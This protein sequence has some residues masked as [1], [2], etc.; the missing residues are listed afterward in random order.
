VNLA[1]LSMSRAAGRRASRPSAPRW[2]PA[3]GSWRG[4]RWRK[5]GV[6]AAVGR[7]LGIA[8]AFV[9]LQQLLAAAPFDLPRLR[10]V[11]VDGRV[12]FFALA[13]SAITA[14]LFGILPAMRSAS[15]GA[16]YETLKSTA[17]SNAGGPTGLRLR[18]MLVALEVGLC[19]ALLVTAGL[20]L[21]SFMRL[22]TIPR[23]FDIERVMAVDVALPWTKYSK[24]TDVTRF[25]EHVLEQAR[26]MR[27]C[28]RRPVSSY[29][30]LE[31]ESWI[32]IVGTENDTRPESQLP[33]P[34]LRFISRAISRRCTSP[35]RGP[36]FHG[37]R[38]Q[39]SDRRHFA[40]PGAQT[41]AESGPR[42]AQTDGYG[43][44]S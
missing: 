15:S 38:P 2:E 26:A 32:D 24:D 13:L 27:E 20:F 36:R 9:G 18:N 11:S 23:G 7:R 29:L 19:A 34:N 37:C 22:T 6:L 8:L 33:N 40:K 43:Q 31:G 12:L 35:A 41:L 39:P 14:L 10:D 1:N 42:R 44:A 3:A 4:N 30:P 17:Y 25:F 21:S 5:T 28:N 16:P